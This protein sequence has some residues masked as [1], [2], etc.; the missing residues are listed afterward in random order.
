LSTE[1]ASIYTFGLI[2]G[3]HARPIASVNDEKTVVRILGFRSA[4]AV[5]SVISW[6]GTAGV[7]VHRVVEVPADPA[8][9]AHRIADEVNLALAGSP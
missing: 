2:V 1:E 8:S 7:S 4:A 3:Q 6:L 5:T 9:P